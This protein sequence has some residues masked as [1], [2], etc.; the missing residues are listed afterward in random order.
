[1]KKKIVFLVNINN[2]D[3]FG[4]IKEIG[5][6][7][8]NRIKGLCALDKQSFAICGQGLPITIWTY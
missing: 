8:R 4:Q 3:N 5:E 1:M 2:D 6:E 7:E